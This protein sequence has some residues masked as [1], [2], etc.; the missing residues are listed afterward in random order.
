MT[1]LEQPDCAKVRP[2]ST[3]PPGLQ[4]ILVV[5]MARG[6]AHD[7]NNVLQIVYAQGAL[8]EARIHPEHPAREDLRR[9]VTA[10]RAARGIVSQLSWIFGCPAFN[11]VPIRLNAVVDE[12]AD[13]L[14][15]LLGDR[16]ALRLR[17][18]ARGDRVL[19]MPG[20]LEH[21]LL[22]LSLNGRDA[23]PRG[24]TLTIATCNSVSPTPG[25][26]LADAPERRHVLLTV[27]DT[28]IGMSADV[29]ARAFQPSFTTKDPEHSSGIGLSFVQAIV[30]RHGGAV[31]LE[32]AAGQGTTARV[33]LP[34]C[35]ASLDRADPWER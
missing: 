9:M 15:C 32:S 10:A 28:G 25:S 19:G 35:D 17:L 16:I 8:A 22:N 14:G 21:V 24:G 20:E 31:E 11:P 6:L 30:D 26:T 33:L 2:P 12:Y 13:V 34:C 4:G 1:E 3:A 7:L 29:L 18:E 27:S 23:M 5:T